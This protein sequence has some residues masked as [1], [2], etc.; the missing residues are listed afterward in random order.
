MH[1]WSPLLES[2][3]SNLE[4]DSA[5]QVLADQLELTGDPRAPLIRHERGLGVVLSPHELDALRARW[6]EW[7]EGLD[8]SGL[9]LRWQHG[10]VTEL[11]AAVPDVERIASFLEHHPLLHIV[12]FAGVPLRVPDLARLLAGPR[13]PRIDELD[14]RGGHHGRETIVCL[15]EHAEHVGL[16][17]LGLAGNPLPAV[18]GTAIAEAR[19]LSSLDWLDLGATALGGTAIAALAGADLTLEA[20]N[21][22]DADATPASIAA[23][24]E[25]SWFREARKVFLAGNGLAPVAA[26]H[27][28]EA[29]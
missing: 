3:R 23:L 13:G 17:G 20:L 12:S 11:W 29:D 15:V 19:G 5:W 1:P 10:F 14:L 24:L 7:L 18:T 4:D 28:A 27:I 8:A 25:A 22:N 6:P 9:H 26:R 16:K 21:L 2:L